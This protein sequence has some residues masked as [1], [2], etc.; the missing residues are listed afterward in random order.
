MNWAKLRWISLGLGVLLLLA[1]P[2]TYAQAPSAARQAQLQE[3]NK[4]ARQVVELRY[5]GKLDEAL[6][7]A[8]RSLEMERRAEG[9]TNSREAEALSRLAEL[10]ELRGEW[11]RALGR[12]REALAVRER[13]NGAAHWQTASA[14]Q[15]LSFT[16]KVAGL[17]APEQSKVQAALLAE[18]QDDR[19]DSDGN[20]AE[21]ERLLMEALENYRSVLGPES[22]EVARVW[23]R[24]GVSR[25]TRSDL[26]KAREAIDRALTI[27]RKV[28]PLDHPDIA[29]SLDH[30]G[31]VQTDLRE[32]AAAKTSHEEALAIRRKTL[33]AGHPDIARSLFGL[34][35]VQ[36]GLGTFA[37]AKTSHEEAL[38]IRRR[39][40]RA[41]HLD[42][43]RSLFG[44]GDVQSGLGDFAAAK[45]SYEEALAIFRQVMLAGHPVIAISLNNLG[46]AQSQ[47]RE[48]AAAK[49]SYEEALAIRRQAL[50][51]GHPDIASTL[52]NLGNVQSSLLDFAA[53]KR[54]HEEAL[55][56]RRKALPPGH[57]DIANS[58]NSLGDAQRELRD[59]A[60][61]KRSP[62]EALAIRRKALPPGHTDIAQSLENLGHLQLDLR[63]FA[64]AKA[65][66]EEALAIRRKALTPDDPQIAV[67]LNN[68]GN[69]QLDLREYEAAKE[70]YEAALVIRRKAL[71]LDRPAIATS[72]SNL[73]AV[74]RDLREFAAAKRNHEEALTI[75]RQALPPD[76]L[77]IAASLSNLGN[78]QCELREFAAAKAGFGEALAI[79]RRTL[80]QGHPDIASTLNNLGIVQCELREYAAAKRSQE[81]A[82]AI[83]SK[84]L[85]PDHPDIAQSL[86]NL[87]YLCLASGINRQEAATRL[88]EASDIYQAE[89]LRMAI[90]QAEPE[91]FWTAALSK[92]SFQLLIDATMTAGMPVDSAYDRVVRGEGSVTAQQRWVRQARDADD[93][94]TRKLLDQLRDVS[95]EILGLSMPSLV[96]EK[97]NSPEDVSTLIRNLFDERARLEQQ[98]AARSKVYQ[99]IQGRAQFR[100]D[101]IRTALPRKTALID[102]VEYHHVEPRAEGP[103][104]EPRMVAFLSRP[105]KDGVVA[106][107]LGRSKALADLIDRW[108]ASYGIGKRPAVGTADPATELRKRLW[109]PL[110]KYLEGAKVILISPDRPLNGLPWAALPGAKQG[111]FL[112]H[113]Y[114]FAV[115]PVPQLLPE[116]LRAKPRPEG[117][118]PSL[119]LAGGIDFG[120]PKVRAAGVPPGNLPP[121]PLFRQLPGAEGEVN[122]VGAEFKQAFRDAPQPKVLSKDA[123]TKLAVVA[124]AARHR[125]VHLA[126]HGFFADEAEQSTVS[127]A[128]RSMDL[129][130]S[131]LH[132]RPEATWLHPGL[133]SGVVFAGVNRSDR[134]PKETILTAFEA[135]ELELGQVDLLVLSACDTGRGQVAGG[136]GVLGLQRAFQLAGARAVV[137]SLWKVP[138]DETRLLMREFYGR[139]WSDKP[140]SRAEALRQAQLWMLEKGKDRGGKDRS[141]VELPERPQGPPSPYIWAAFVLSGDW[142]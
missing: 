53:A 99:D 13:V 127:V 105:E 124:A 8:E 26:I 131:G 75:R 115:V 110:A 78:V 5:A 106:V 116:I 44:L 7:A 54:S 136:E 138:D 135:S 130:R 121:L 100:S 59:F 74:Q 41:G 6:A 31:A 76:D 73:G 142:R 96:G 38:A 14:K 42:I 65:S 2:S 77:D 32:F 34:G 55:A 107:P 30:L 28:L 97:S 83:R 67:S 82:L 103:A 128:Q 120:E 45:R 113:E 17:G 56:I 35:N 114:A 64:A 84:A 11:D 102:L 48:F 122:D 63:E 3:A 134:G 58:L 86:N 15:S 129:L 43:A 126:T 92:A 94:E 117:E 118:S 24:I 125:F 139:I 88:A 10:H 29:Q 16:E 49:R 69:A 21:S 46:A 62:E 66:L 119:L 61:A 47:L 85:R 141:G 109:E 123:A 36:Y 52:N 80:P 57:P 71:P 20:F 137:A 90:A 89:Q 22:L 37:A 27:R 4:L 108:R 12:R 72:L 9:M 23:L 39:A 18:E 140:L 81:E 93:P 19:L 112:V 70:S 101:D 40:L 51:A 68:L 79:Q 104:I 132:L 33:R 95:R 25:A 98:L 87:G 60:A 1:M 50:P 111:T 133:L 91:Q